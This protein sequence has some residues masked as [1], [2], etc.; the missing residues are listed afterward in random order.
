MLDLI[1]R[2]RGFRSSAAATDITIPGVQNPHCNASCSTTGRL[3]RMH[4]RRRPEPFDSGDLMPPRIDRQHHAR[5]DRP[6]IQMHR[7]RTTRAAIANQFRSGQPQML[8]KRTE[9]GH[10][11]FNCKLKSLSV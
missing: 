4:S 7:A 3:H 10:P 5:S 9:Q 2:R 6:T 1:N 11:R 8:P